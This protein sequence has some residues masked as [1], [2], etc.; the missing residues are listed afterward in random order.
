MVTFINDLIKKTRGELV[1]FCWS[2]ITADESPNRSSPEP[3]STLVHDTKSSGDRSVPYSGPGR[4]QQ[5]RLPVSPP[6]DNP[7]NLPD[8]VDKGT[9]YSKLKTPPNGDI[10]VVVSHVIDPGFFWIVLIEHLPKLEA[11]DE[12]LR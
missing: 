7:V 5:A 2:L 9:Y 3:V 11:L 8:A 12:D 4:P 10:E 1:S 6:W